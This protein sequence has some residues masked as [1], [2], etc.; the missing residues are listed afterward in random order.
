MFH[1]PYPEEMDSSEQCKGHRAERERRRRFRGIKCLS[2]ECTT[3]PAVSVAWAVPTLPWH[4]ISLGE[5]M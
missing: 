5:A 2:T 1:Q 4:S 3:A